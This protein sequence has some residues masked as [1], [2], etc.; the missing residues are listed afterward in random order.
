MPSLVV[1][2]FSP[3]ILVSSINKT[4]HHDIT[5]ILLKVALNNHNA[6]PIKC[7]VT[8]IK[9]QKYSLFSSRFS[10][11][12]SLFNLKI[13]L[14][15]IPQCEFFILTGTVS[16]L[17][18]ILQCSEKNSNEV[19]YH[20]SEFKLLH[21]PSTNQTALFSENIFWKFMIKNFLYWRKKIWKPEPI[22]FHYFPIIDPNYPLKFQDNQNSMEMLLSSSF[23]ANITGN[24]T[25]VPPQSN[26]SFHHIWYEEQKN[27]ML[28]FHLFLIT[29]S[30]FNSISF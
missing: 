5:V 1:S 15:F 25:K 30:F 2:W 24:Q 20:W 6:S 10:L 28:S 12:L 23:N 19:V 22:C 8:F 13:H 16:C 3:D 4:N 21:I 11:Q 26:H 18:V 7:Q 17:I 27:I 29:A 9:L 14:F